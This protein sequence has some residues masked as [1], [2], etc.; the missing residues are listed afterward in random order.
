M[1]VEEITPVAGIGLVR[2]IGD[3]ALLNLLFVLKAIQ[4]I[5]RQNDLG[6]RI[7][8]LRQSR[9]GSCVVEYRHSL[10][11]LEVSVEIWLKSRVSLLASPCYR[12][13][14]TDILD[15]DLYTALNNANNHACNDMPDCRNMLLWQ[16]TR[17]GP[18]QALESLH[19]KS[20]AS[21]TSFKWE[22]TKSI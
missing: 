17:N 9:N 12:Y 10:H 6:S 3:I 13:L 14:S 11:R 1:D 20:T 5:R 19:L 21:L 2:L 15:A 8:L 18:Q 4:G 16:Q 22:L 7:W